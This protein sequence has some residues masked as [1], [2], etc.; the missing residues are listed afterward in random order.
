MAFD[1]LAKKQR[2]RDWSLSSMSIDGWG[3]EAR[4][5]MAAAPDYFIVWYTI[6]SVGLGIVAS[7]LAFMLGKESARRRSK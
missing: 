5:A 4:K 3:D 6:K 7:G 2:A 1:L